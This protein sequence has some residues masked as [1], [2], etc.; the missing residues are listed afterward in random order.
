VKNLWGFCKGREET[1]IKMGGK[2]EI[3]EKRKFSEERFLRMI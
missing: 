2:T 1:R 3:F